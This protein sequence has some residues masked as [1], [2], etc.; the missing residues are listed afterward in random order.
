MYEPDSVPPG[1]H[2]GEIVRLAR[3]LG[4]QPEDILDFSNNADTLIF[5]LTEELI[6]TTPVPFAWYP[7]TTCSAL[8]H[9]IAEHE[10]V[11]PEQVIV[12][13]GSSELVFLALSVLAPARALVIAPI[14]SEYVQACQRLGIPYELHVLKESNEFRL[15]EADIRAIA[16]RADDMLILCTPANPAGVADAGMTALLGQLRCR[17]VLADL[18]YR[19]F[20]HPDP[21]YARDCHHRFAGQLSGSTELLSLGSFTKYFC[22]PGIRLGYG[23]G[24]AAL[25]NRLQQR[26][27]PWMVSGFH[28]AL[29]RRFLEQ[30]DAFR[31]ARKDFSAQREAFRRGLLATGAF[32]RANASDLNFIAARLRPGLSGQAVFHHLLARRLLVRLC[33]AIPGMPANYLRMQIKTPAENALLYAALR[34]ATQAF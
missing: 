25:I 22:C 17:T 2:G 32:D 21:A 7:D 27:A 5:P 8:A 20:L 13:N 12:A 3:L 9:D 34:D 33:D 1:Q 24:S 11:T 16:R 15:D 28:E 4:C 30:L 31:A 23:L 14:F 29:G 26:R 19:E 6:R 10:N 18:A